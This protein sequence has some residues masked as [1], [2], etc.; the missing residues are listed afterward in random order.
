MNLFLNMIQKE[1]GQINL[2]IIIF[3]ME[4]KISTINKIIQINM[5]KAYLLIIVEVFDKII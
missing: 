1:D 2:E 3:Q 5:I 4:L